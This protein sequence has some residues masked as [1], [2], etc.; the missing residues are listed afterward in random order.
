MNAWGNNSVADYLLF[1]LKGAVMG[2][3]DAVPGVSGGT[4]AVAANIYDRII[5]AVRCFDGAALR[6]LLHRRPREFWRRVDGAFLLPLGLGIG[7]GL[8]FSASLALYLIEHYPEPL[9]GFFIGL[10]AA[11]VW[12]ARAGTD[13]R[14]WRNLAMAFAAALL[15]LLISMA[16]PQ[17]G[18]PGAAYLFFCGAVAVAA[19]LLPG[20]SGAFILLLLGAYQYMLAALTALD[21]AAISIFLAGCVV[22][23]LLMSR[24]AAWLLRRHRRRA[25]GF[26]CG[27]LAGSLP[28]LWPW[29]LAGG[30]ESTARFL[31]SRPVWPDQYVQLAGR[32]PMIAVSIAALLLG[33]TLTLS[34]RRFSNRCD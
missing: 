12:I 25:Y 7:S 22:G 4:I 10:V 8:F 28:A 17:P 13:F 11:A 19:M 32:E 33:L 31:A 1:Y 9:R 21:I 30:A 23:V 26:I 24:A 3:S 34:A 15:V 20:L 5:L 2:M 18:Q 6:L 16:G 27:L 14:D 29:Q